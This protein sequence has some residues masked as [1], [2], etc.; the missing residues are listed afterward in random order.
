MRPW[1]APFFANNKW[2]LK[3]YAQPESF[4]AINLLSG[5]IRNYFDTGSARTLHALP[6]CAKVGGRSDVLGLS[7]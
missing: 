3:I 5:Q 6:L 2:V 1:G 4:R 7:G